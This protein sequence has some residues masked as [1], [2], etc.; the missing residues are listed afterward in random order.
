MKVVDHELDTK[1]W[2]L[3]SDS[4]L[5]SLKAVLIRKGNKFPS[6]P[7]APRDLHEKYKTTCRK[8]PV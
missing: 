6:G 2:R 7:V 4:S 5:V 1:E 8:D 3:F